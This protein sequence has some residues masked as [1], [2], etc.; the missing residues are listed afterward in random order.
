MAIKEQQFDV[1]LHTGQVKVG[2]IHIVATS[3]EAAYTAESV[4]VE[5]GFM[6]KRITVTLASTNQVFKPAGAK[7]EWH[8]GMYLDAE[9]TTGTAIRG[10]SGLGSTNDKYFCWISYQTSNANSTNIR[11]EQAACTFPASSLATYPVGS[12]NWNASTANTG[13]YVTTTCYRGFYIGGAS[14]VTM[15]ATSDALRDITYVAEG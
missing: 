8:Q 1:G 3:S 5:T 13:I 12:S 10:S 11:V 2:N 7:M 9:E 14:I 4:Y 6:P 15:A